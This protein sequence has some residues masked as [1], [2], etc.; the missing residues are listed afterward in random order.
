[1]LRKNNLRLK[2]LERNANIHPKFF[3][4]EKLIIKR[5]FKSIST[6]HGFAINASKN[7]F[8]VEKFGMKCQHSFPFMFSK[9]YLIA[10]QIITQ[11]IFK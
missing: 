8:K 9:K 4:Q 6:N 10:N 1:M 7:I 5:I 2:I 3:F 11:K